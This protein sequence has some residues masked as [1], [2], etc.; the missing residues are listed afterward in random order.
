MPIEHATLRCFIN[1]SFLNLHSLNRAASADSV[2]FD[3]DD[4]N[5]TPLIYRSVSHQSSE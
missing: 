4:I 2:V 5:V 3:D 1:P